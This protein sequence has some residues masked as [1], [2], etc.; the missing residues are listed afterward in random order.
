M[1]IK[2]KIYLFHKEP[3]TH[4]L[5][6]VLFL[7]FPKKTLHLT[8]C[9][10]L[11]FSH[12]N[13]NS[14]ISLFFPFCKTFIRCNFC[15][16]AALLTKKKVART[17]TMFRL[18]RFVSRSAMRPVSNSALAQSSAV[19]ATAP[20]VNAP[21]VSRKKKKKE[22]FRCCGFFFFFFF[23]LVGA[24]AMAKRIL[25]FCHMCQYDVFKSSC[26][27]LRCGDASRCALKNLI[28]FFFF[29]FF[30]FRFFLGFRR[31]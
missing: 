22:I 2:K 21:N 1:N 20:I 4:F 23:F 11:S 19:R 6:F 26:V 7:R 16:E 28:F 14:K 10:F 25:L 18:S 5:Q 13:C 29:F 8:L 24:N 12:I 17:S 30:F 27:K 31:Y 3:T 9:E 15:S